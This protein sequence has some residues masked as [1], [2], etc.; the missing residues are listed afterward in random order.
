MT[1]K[2]LLL[3]VVSLVCAGLLTQCP[4]HYQQKEVAPQTVHATLNI[5]NLIKECPEPVEFFP[6]PPARGFPIAALMGR[7][8]NCLGVADL[9][10]VAWEGKDS[11][12]HRT[13]ANLLILMYIDFKN[14]KNPDKH[15]RARLIKIMPMDKDNE[16][17]HVSFYSLEA[18]SIKKENNK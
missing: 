16:H 8:H 14:E 3:I 9:L 7:Y 6:I 10:M 2:K 17:V 4:Y 18:R 13:A 12:T 5:D 11:E 15:L 1:R